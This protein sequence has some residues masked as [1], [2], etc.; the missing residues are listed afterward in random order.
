MRGRPLAG[1]G[2]SGPTPP[3]GYALWLEFDATYCYEDDAKTDPCET[4]DGI[5]VADDRGTNGWDL[6]QTTAANRPTLTSYGASFDGTN[7]QLIRTT[8]SGELD[9]ANFTVAFRLQWTGAT[10]AAQ[11]LLGKLGSNNSGSWGIWL[12]YSFADDRLHLFGNLGAGNTGK[13]NALTGLFAGDQ[14]IVVVASGTSVTYYRNGAAFG[15]D[16]WEGSLA[17]TQSFAL[18]A[19]AESPTAAPADAAFKRLVYYPSALA[20]QDLTDLFTFMGP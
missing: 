19:R 13:S 20:G 1:G 9:A 2:S 16:S 8:G 17:G 6:T 4:G 15:T 7:D 18:G 10:P 11:F 5:A 12:E 3:A 14:T